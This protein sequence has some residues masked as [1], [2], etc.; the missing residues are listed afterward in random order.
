MSLLH[1]KQFAHLLPN[2]DK[3]AISSNLTMNLMLSSLRSR[4][5]T[6]EIVWIG[7][8]WLTTRQTH[9]DFLVKDEQNYLVVALTVRTQVLLYVGSS[10]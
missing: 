8:L 4:K 3:T 6:K 7:H 5:R 1:H 2:K 9:F 10:K